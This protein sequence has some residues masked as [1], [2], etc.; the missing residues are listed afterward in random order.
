ML[1]K[2][3]LTLALLTVCLALPAL[4]GCEDEIETET[5]TEVKDMPVETRMVV[6]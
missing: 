2:A 3:L 6:E 4:S 1:K 5:H